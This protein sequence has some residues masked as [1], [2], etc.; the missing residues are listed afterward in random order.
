MKQQPTQNNEDLNS[1]IDVPK[2]DINNLDQTKKT[3]LDNL[4]KKLNEDKH[5]NSFL[6]NI[7][8][9]FSINNFKSKLDDDFKFNIPENKYQ[10]SDYK[11]PEKYSNDNMDY[12]QHYSNINSLVRAS[13]WSKRD[14]EN[15]NYYNSISLEESYNRFSTKLYEQLEKKDERWQMEDLAKLSEVFWDQIYDF[16]IQ[17]DILEFNDYLLK[18]K[19]TLK[20]LYAWLYNHNKNDNISA[21]VCIQHHEVISKIAEDL[22]Y[23][24]WTATSDIGTPHRFSLIKSKTKWYHWICYG[25]LFTTNT[26]NQLMTEY[27]K[28]SWYWKWANSW[29]FSDADL[30]LWWVSFNIFDTKWNKIYEWQTKTQESVLNNISNWWLKGFDN[31]DYIQSGFKEYKIWQN[32]DVSITKLT[33]TDWNTDFDWSYNFHYKQEHENGNIKVAQIAGFWVSQDIHLSEWTTIKSANIDSGLI[34]NIKSWKNNNIN[35]QISNNIKIWL[36]EVNY[37]KNEIDTND[38]KDIIAKNYWGSINFGMKTGI[39]NKNWWVNLG[40][41]LYWAANFTEKTGLLTLV[42]NL[43]KTSG[44]IGWEWYYKH[45]DLTFKLGWNTWIDNNFMTDTSK[46]DWKS[47]WYKVNTWVEKEIKKWKIGAEYTYSKHLQEETHNID[48]NIEKWKVMASTNIEQTYFG[49]ELLDNKQK[50]T[51][52]IDYSVNKSLIIWWNYEKDYS[53]YK[54]WIKIKWSI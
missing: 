30:W 10:E 4:W 21:W 9:S 31:Y 52:A 1:L 17:E 39:D 53:W 20:D 45:N 5:L 37:W 47:N 49:S 14:S 13:M 18:Q 22:G 2:K 25:R 32:H 3:D 34:A 42:P 26:L 12:Y 24:A 46:I 8:Y 6:S 36:W 16:Q 11:S 15:K 51:A 23:H 7:N 33:G 50:I 41:N 29:D 48:L 43:L 38:N 54:T 27:S 40:Y 19:M 44:N 35:T 28:Y